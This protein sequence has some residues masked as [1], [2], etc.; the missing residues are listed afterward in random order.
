MIFFTNTNT[1]KKAITNEEKL[2]ALISG[3]EI[4]QEP[5]DEIQRQNTFADSTVDFSQIIQPLTNEKNDPEREEQ[6]SQE[7]ENFAVDDNDV[8]VTELIAGN[9]TKELDLYESNTLDFT[10]ESR[11]FS[12]IHKKQTKPRKESK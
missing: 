9:E 11:I 10:A 6:E 7:E 8:I 12:T 5:S 4:N 2:Q 3:K 1:I